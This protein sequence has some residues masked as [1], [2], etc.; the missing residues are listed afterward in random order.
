MSNFQL[1]KKRKRGLHLY[2]HMPLDFDFAM[3]LTYVLGVRDKF[4]REVKQKDAVAI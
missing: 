2:I 1:S 3:P 4:H